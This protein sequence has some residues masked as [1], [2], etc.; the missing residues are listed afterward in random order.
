MIRTLAR[1]LASHPEI[2]DWIQILA[3]QRQI[4]SRLRPII[5][6]FDH[7]AILD[8]GSGTGRIAQEL[9]L[10]P[11]QV[12][13]A[14]EPL[15]LNRKRGVHVHAV[16]ADA[17]R[18][19]FPGGSFDVTLC[20]NV[21]HHLAGEDW[22][23]ALSEI[24]RVTRRKLIFMDAVRDDGRLI[25]RALWR[26]DRGS[27]PR[28]RAE[29]LASVERDFAI[30]EAHDFSVYHRYLLCL[31]TP[32]PKKNTHGTPPPHFAQSEAVTSGSRT[33]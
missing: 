5:R 31:A 11:V 3:G 22:Y 13:L 4:V 16:A 18:L 10:S 17:G 2:Y 26:Y 27:N 30:D 14:L 32:R 12:D 21:S 15:L 28:P 19:P 1:R 9:G 20:I 29:L 24:S 8:A 7:A 23:R 6:R 33:V 25:S